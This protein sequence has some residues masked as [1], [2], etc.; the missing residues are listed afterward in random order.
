MIE[1]IVLVFLA[2]KIGRLAIVKGEPAGRW[3]L[4]LV[5]F[6]IAA[7]FVGAFIGLAIFGQD[8]LFSCML[9][10]F[11]FAI[12]AYFIINNHLSKMPDVLSEDDIDNIGR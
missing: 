11:A 6:W 3:R 7:E 2:L 5:L 8:N 1:I 10:A 9:V 12:S 4:R